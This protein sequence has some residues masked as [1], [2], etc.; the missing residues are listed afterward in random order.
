MKRIFKNPPVWL[1]ILSYALALLSATGSLV[2]LLFD[3]SKMPLAIVAYTLFG[4]AGVSLGYS[5]YTIVRFAP[6]IKSFVI[7]Q[8]EKSAFAKRYVKDFGYRA[9]FGSVISLSFSALFGIF[10][11]VM[12]I[13]SRSVW[14]GSLSLYYILMSLIYASIVLNRKRDI[15]AGHKIYLR[16]GILLAILN[17][18]LSAAIAQ[19]IFE[20]KGF[21]YAGLM[22]YAFAAFA[23]YK[24]TMAIIQLV[25]ARHAENP[26]VHAVAFINLSSGAVSILA[27]QTAL[28]ST[29]SKGEV[30]ISTFNT[31]TG[32]A[33]SLL[34]IGISIFMIIKGRKKTNERE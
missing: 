34:S 24:I 6:K 33:V 29:F 31:L 8:I 12:G 1:I 25:R 7:K 10:N 19:M 14:Y 20:G 22:I 16:C 9:L 18:A 30:N 32:T 26:L 28:L 27:L 3:Y 13:L 2:I 4:L 5:V 17:T 21:M 23:F 15:E 11:G